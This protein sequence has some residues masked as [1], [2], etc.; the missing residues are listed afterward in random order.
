MNLNL[1]Y[2]LKFKSCDVSLNNS[3]KHSS[4]SLKRPWLCNSLVNNDCVFLICANHREL[5]IFNILFTLWKN[6]VKILSKNPN[7]Y[8]YIY[9]G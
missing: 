6:I 8:E 4:K 5:F 3:N 2:F 7:I 9:S 1:K